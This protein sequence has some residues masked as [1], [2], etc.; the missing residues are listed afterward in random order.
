MLM[1]RGWPF[2]GLNSCVQCYDSLSQISEFSS[3]TK[4]FLKQNN[5]PKVIKINYLTIDKR[6]LILD[7]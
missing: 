3:S 4:Y 7:V 5:V 6:N 2:K 1:L